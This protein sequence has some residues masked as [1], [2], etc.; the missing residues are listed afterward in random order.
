MGSHARFDAQLALTAVLALAACAAAQR[1]TVGG[2]PCVFPFTFEGQEYNDCV[3]SE[4]IE[5]C[6]T[7]SG[8]FDMCDPSSAPSASVATPVAAT[9]TPPVSFANGGSDC[10]GL[11]AGIGFSSSLPVVI[12]DSGGQ[13]IPDEPKI[14]SYACTCNAPGGDVAGSVGIEIRGSTSARD[15]LKKSFAVEFRDEQG[16]DMDVTFMGFP[17]DSD[18]ILYGPE[19]DRTLG[20]KNYLTMALARAMGRY[21]SLTKYCE[22]FLVQDGRQLSIDH[23]NGIYI[24]MEKIKRDKNRVD[25]QKN[26]GDISGGYIFKYDNDNFDE[27]DKKIVSTYTKLEFVCVYPKK[28]K[29]SQEQLDWMGS[30][31]G[32]MEQALQSQDRNQWTRYIDEG[33]FVD[34]FL[35]TEMTKNPDGYRGSTYYYKDAGGPLAA[36]P[37]WDYNE[38]YGYCCG[39]PIEGYQN[40]GE[41]TGISG[42]SAI[43]PEGWR[44][45]ICIDRERCVVDPDDGTSQYFMMLMLVRRRWDRRRCKSVSAQR[46]T[47]SPQWTCASF[48]GGAHDHCSWVHPVVMRMYL[49]LTV[50]THVDAGMHECIR[51]K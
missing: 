36:G 3:E 17:E 26:E 19:M 48:R 8:E 6:S 40:N 41:S 4:G 46:L 47:F 14:Q 23:Y 15:F 25:V 7:A 30:Y 34:Y 12:I 28:T 37:A 5:W 32:E 2:Q 24:A 13:Q 49:A 45:N 50:M 16:N 43:S 21:A 22:V 39:Y 31:M 1:S 20:M 10:C 9:P 51:M 42:G 35:I 29:V 27:G 11:L 44:Y 18:F 38:A 33:T